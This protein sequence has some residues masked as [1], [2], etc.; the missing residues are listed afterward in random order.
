LIKI[1]ESVHSAG[2]VYND[3]KL[4][5]I[6][7]GYNESLPDKYSKDDCFENISLFLI[8]FGFATPY[9]DSKTGKFLP[10]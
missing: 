10:K 2:F 3:L 1:F 8:D 7:I 5:N 4:D 9:I 6:M